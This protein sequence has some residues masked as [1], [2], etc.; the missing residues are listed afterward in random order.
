M[1]PTSPN[2][3]LYAVVRDPLSWFSCASELSV[4][5]P[6]LGAEITTAFAALNTDRSRTAARLMA[7]PRAF[8]LL[9][10][11]AVENYLKG[12]WLSRNA[13][14]A[15]DPS[16]DP[17]IP[18]HKLTSIARQAGVSLTTAHEATLEL[19][20]RSVTWYARYPV[21]KQPEAFQLFGSQSGEVERVLALLEHLRTLAAGYRPAVP[22]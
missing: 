22:T 19:L 4:L 13:A 2:P 10:G 18:A 14:K 15:V 21:P 9:A 8:F 7:V 5:L 6:E 16:V 3:L 17:F 1:S 20:E 11:Y 12:L